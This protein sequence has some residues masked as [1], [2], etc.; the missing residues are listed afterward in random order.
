MDVRTFALLK[1]MIKQET[2]G[3]FTCK[4]DTTI[5]NATSKR[6]SNHARDT[7][8]PICSSSYPSPLTNHLGFLM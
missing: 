5:T 6:V 3:Q 8:T 1:L 7:I 2:K 4:H